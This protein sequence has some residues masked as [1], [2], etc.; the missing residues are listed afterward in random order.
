MMKPIYIFLFMLLGAT[1]QAQN[2]KELKTII[3]SKNYVFTAQSVTPLGGRFRHLTSEYDVRVSPDSVIVYLPY[4]GRSYSA[5]LDPSQSGIQFT[6][7]DFTYQ[8]TDR[9][10]GG[11][12]I[13]IKPK[14]AQDVRELTLNIAS[15]GNATLQVNS[16]S[17][18]SI[19]FGGT[20][21]QPIP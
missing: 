13:S 20:V 7:T 9:K 11:W 19:S 2:S 5:P 4:F 14:D 1:A 6:S 15:G 16:N 12:I 17:R 18:Q 3:D 10:K 21:H 8:Q